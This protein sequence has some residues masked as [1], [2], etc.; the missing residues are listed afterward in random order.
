M[1]MKIAM[2]GTGY[3]GLV[4]GTCL[5]NLGNDVICVDIDEPKIEA[6][7]KGMI[8]IYEPGLKELL[9]Q[10]IRGSRLHFTTDA[11][12]AI[13]N[14]DVIFI[15][16]GTPQD[17]TG[18][19]DLAA[20][21]AVAENIGK[22]MNGYK[23]VVDKSTVPVGT[24]DKVKE[25]IIKNQQ[26]PQDVD[27]VSNPEFLREGEAIKDFMNPDRIVIGTDSEKAKDIMIKIYKGIER[28]GKPILITDIKTAEIIKYASNAFLATKISFMNEIA[29]LCE[30]TGGDV[31][32]VA[33]GM[34]L[35]QRIG[36]R[37]LQ[38][39]IGYGGSCFP[40]D[41]RALLRRGEEA[42]YEFKIIKAVDEVNEAQKKSLLPKVEKILGTIEGKN[43]AV[44][45]LAFKPKTDDIRE[46]PSVI[47]INQLLEK[48]AKITAFDPAAMENVKK[49]LGDKISYGKDPYSTVEN[50]D[51]L[52][53]VTE[54][55][56]FR[57][58][59]MEKIKAVM[60]SPNVVD[61]RNVYTPGDMKE[62]GI[63]YIG[64][65]RK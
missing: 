55:D 59:D 6:L 34:G 49:E 41:V 54:W 7:N 5:A 36:P 27:L 15:T 18:K 38:A 43:I 37:F 63:N 32:L 47:L 57:Y 56:Q 10:N 60:K 4:T 12:H 23:V 44:W 25:T 46:A 2:F 39:G 22:H 48:G 16:V 53:L 14:S 35:D 65:G 51:C 11:K 42:G 9:E 50:A 21:F 19:A 26:A 62:H 3:V 1:T 45:G 17:D 13:E 20:V 61:G 52:V 64:V 40:K 29:Q 31:K 28:T 8:P 30:K 58:L 24:A 33:R